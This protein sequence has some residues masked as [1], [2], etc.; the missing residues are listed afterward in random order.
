MKTST[1]IT[2]G[3]VATLSG[4]LPG[5]TAADAVGDAAD[6]EVNQEPGAGEAPAQLQAEKTL[7]AAGAGRAS[8]DI[9]ASA[10]SLPAP[11]EVYIENIATGGVGCPDSSTVGTQIS[12]DRKSFLVIFDEMQLTNPPGPA[13]QN[14]NCTAGVALHI[15][16]G[17]QFS[18][19]TVNT[20]GYAFLSPGQTGRQT[21]KYFFAGSPIGVAYHST[22]KGLFDDDYVFTDSVGIQS[23]SQCGGS[24]IFAIDTSLNLNVVGNPQG[25]AVFNTATVDGSLKKQFH[26]QWQPCH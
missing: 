10:A 9:N 8:D 15:P 24:Q 23:W 18:V 11:S 2:V 14:I 5:C 21:S 12:S 6:I 7:R 16:P 19:A 3:L 20:R 1:W 17:W 26:W 22:L 4:S 25:N 13:V